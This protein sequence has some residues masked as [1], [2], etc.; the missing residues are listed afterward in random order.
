MITFTETFIAIRYS[1]YLA[2]APSQS[3]ESTFNIV[4][5]FTLTQESSRTTRASS[6]NTI[7]VSG[8]S[9]E[10][11]RSTFVN[12]Y[13]PVMH[14]EDYYRQRARQNES[15]A[16]DIFH[17]Q[18][19]LRLLRTLRGNHIRSHTVPMSAAYTHTYIYI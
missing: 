8:F 11:D 2:F 17:R 6:G 19:G 4:C 14:R 1:R 13:L 12:R 10:K 5:Y 18:V 3:L 16:S 15:D 7:S 9:E